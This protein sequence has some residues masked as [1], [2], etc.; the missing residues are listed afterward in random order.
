MFS[1]CTC[2]LGTQEFDALIACGIV[3]SSPFAN[4]VRF[5]SMLKRRKDY[6]MIIRAPLTLIIGLEPDANPLV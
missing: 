4:K 2:T 1:S 5:F 6:G 3:V